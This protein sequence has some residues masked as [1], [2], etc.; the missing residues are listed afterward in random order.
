MVTAKLNF[1]TRVKKMIRNIS[2]ILGL[3]LFLLTALYSP[4]RAYEAMV[5][6]V[7][8]GDSF[9]VRHGHRIET[10]RLYG[11]DC[12]EYRQDGW[13]KAKKMT[14]TL[15]GKNSVEIYPVDIDRY[16]RTVAFV[17]VQGRLIN[18]ELV[19]N[20]WAWL[21]RRYCHAQPF[22]RQLDK[23][24]QEARSYRRGIWEKNK[25]IPP[26]VWRRRKH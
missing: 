17:R 2:S 9:R 7:L 16:G 19:G 1:E 10:I 21:Y 20:G 24:E 22:C 18:A 4:A 15:V 6:H 5:T 8:D 11:I 12:P 25:P 26:W 23:L 13:Q 3:G 14:K